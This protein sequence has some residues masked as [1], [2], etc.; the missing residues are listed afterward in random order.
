V[1]NIGY[2]FDSRLANHYINSNYSL[3]KHVD[4]VKAPRPG[5]GIY[6]YYRFIVKNEGYRALFKGLG[7]NLL[8]VAPY[9]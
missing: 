3:N 1:L 4:V 8:G 5:T 2:N 9:R 7:P 6:L